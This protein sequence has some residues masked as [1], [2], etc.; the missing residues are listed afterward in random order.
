MKNPLPG[1]RYDQPASPSRRRALGV[2]AGIGAGWMLTSLGFAP[3]SLAQSAGSV[4]LVTKPIPGTGESLP[5]IGIGTARRFDVGAPEAERAPLREVLRDL[6]RLGGRLVDTAPSYGN[7]ETVIG[8]LMQELGNRDEIFLAT[9]VGAGRNGA[10]AG[11][12]EMEASMRRLRTD[13][14][15]LLMVHNLA[16]IDDMLPVLREW[17]A[18]GRIRY[19]GMSTSF[20]RQYDDFVAVMEREQL[21]FIQVD[22]AIDNRSAEARILPLAAERGI[23][24]L[25]NLPFGRGRVFRAFGDQPIPD[26]AAEYGIESWAQF[27]L[28]YVVSHPAVTVAIPGTARPDYL[29]DNLGA[30]RAPMPDEAVRERMAALVA[31]A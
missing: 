17:K 31:A 7:A 11:L 13:R 21:D 16:G 30:A 19:L 29:R 27:A 5:V 12:A 22:Y 15:D 3:A 8:D 28:K 4:E 14:F 20:E 26:W 1:R 10:A 9:K 25:T 24:V 2:G 6:P 23:A 18:A